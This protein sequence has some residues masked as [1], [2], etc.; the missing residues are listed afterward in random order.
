MRKNRD[1]NFQKKIQEQKAKAASVMSQFTTACVKCGV[2]SSKAKL[3]DLDEGRLCLK[4]LPEGMTGF[5]ALNIHEDNRV[6]LQEQRDNPV[7][8]EDFG[9][10]A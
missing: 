8:P 2:L 3:F 1:I 9:G 10:W 6:R 4:C 5:E 7:R